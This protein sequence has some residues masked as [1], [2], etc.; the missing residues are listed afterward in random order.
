MNNVIFKEKIR[1]FY[2]EKTSTLLKKF[3]GLSWT[4]F[5]VDTPEQGLLWAKKKENQ[6][7]Q[8]NY[9]YSGID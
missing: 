1:K 8:E 3:R 2:C 6:L 5:A 9:D 7:I 4:N